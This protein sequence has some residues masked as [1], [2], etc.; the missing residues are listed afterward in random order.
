MN[1]RSRRI[2]DLAEA[3]RK[4]ASLREGDRGVLEVTACGAAAVPALHA[5]LCKREPSGIF[6]PRCRAVAALK[7]LDAR[8]ELRAFLGDPPQSDDPVERT[9]NDAVIGAAALALAELG[10]EADFPLIIRLAMHRPVPGVLAALGMFRR[11][12]AL[13]WLIRGLAEDFTRREAEES[14][15]KLGATAGPA[16]IE[17]AMNPTPSAAEE[18]ESSRRRRRSALQLLA[19]LSPSQGLLRSTFQRL[20]FDKGDWIAVLAAKILLKSSV[21]AERRA[22]VGRLLALLR[23]AD[24]LLGTEIEDSLAT[25]FDI[26][27]ES[28]SALKTKEPPALLDRSSSAE[29]QRALRRIEKGGLAARDQAQTFSK[30]DHMTNTANL[31]YRPGVGIM[32]LNPSGNVFVGRRTDVPDGA[33][34]MPQ[35]GVDPGEQPHDAAMRELKEEIGTDRAV[36]I[37]ESKDWFT[38]ELPAE[39]LGI[40]WQGRYRGQRQK[41]FLMRFTGVDSDINL[42]SGHPEFDAWKWLPTVDLPK[43]AVS[44]KRRLYTD[45]LQEFG[46]V[47]DR[48]D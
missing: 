33:W 26:A 6:E 4:L 36:L 3:L 5:I 31:P 41:W 39:L 38:Y 40:A 12:E 34:Q 13:P 35:G 14:I 45:L 7:A 42:A 10:H 27:Q 19:E 43:L 18:T 16:L 37:A 8:N 15:R 30:R 20:L 22:A 32:L 1:T 48:P 29:F 46:T 23:T 47:C 17:A 25:H 9:G 44:F 21:D 2:P 24:W 28:I 11:R